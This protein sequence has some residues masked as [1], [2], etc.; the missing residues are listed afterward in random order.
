MKC[1]GKI[2]NNKKSFS[3]HKRWCSGVCVYK[4]TTGYAGIHSWVR[5]R[6]YKPN[7]CE[8]CKIKKAIDLANISGNYERNIDDYLYLCRSCHKLMD[9]SSKTKYLLYIN[10][11]NRKRDEGGR[12]I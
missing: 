7:F 4:D 5:K 6:K 10:S 11:L 1:C 12:F 9:Y 3:N 8:R 2:F